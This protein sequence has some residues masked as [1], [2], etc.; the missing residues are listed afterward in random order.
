MNDNDPN[1]RGT[2]MINFLLVDRSKIFHNDHFN[3]A[4]A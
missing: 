4:K 2:L 1:I 3:W